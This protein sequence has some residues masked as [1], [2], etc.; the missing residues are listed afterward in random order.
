MYYCC[1]SIGI[2]DILIDIGQLIFEFSLV[3]I[4][5]RES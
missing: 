1:N 2:E 3:S 4:I 5:E